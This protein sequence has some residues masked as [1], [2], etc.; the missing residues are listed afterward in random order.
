LGNILDETDNATARKTEPGFGTY[1]AADAQPLDNEMGE[2]PAWLKHSAP[3]P[4]AG[5]H[6]KQ[7]AVL[8][9]GSLAAL[10]VVF[11]GALWLFD[12]HKNEGAMAVVARAE[13]PAAPAAPA[14]SSASSLPPL[15]LLAPA[16][17]PVAKVSVPVAV[18]PAPAKVRPKEPEKKV[19][20]AKKPAIQPKV[21][22]KKSPVLAK[23]MPA[24][25]KPKQKLLANAAPQPAK[26]HHC[27][28]GELVRDC[29]SRR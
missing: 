24:K 27:R 11:A 15:V 3:P 23:H 29:L 10:A 7:T 17:D 16:S 28:S 12:E 6:W 20:L 5:G 1:D 18:A 26:A 21:K 9:G 19:L 22:A 8:W 14:P 13:L 4:S 2:L 25:P